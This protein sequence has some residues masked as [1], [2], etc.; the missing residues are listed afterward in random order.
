MGKPKRGKGQ[1]A[2]FNHRSTVRR[3]KRQE[4]KKSKNELKRYYDAKE[5]EMWYAEERE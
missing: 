5:M 2:L 1:Y 4:R 3:C